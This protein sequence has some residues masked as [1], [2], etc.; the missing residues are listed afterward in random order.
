[1]EVVDRPEEEATGAVEVEVAAGKSMS[2]ICIVHLCSAPGGGG[3]DG[4]NTHYYWQHT[5]TDTIF[6]HNRY[7]GGGYGGGN[8]G[9]DSGWH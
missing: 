9:G 2:S 7:G 4:R 8:R 6:I 3:V 1:M 5:H